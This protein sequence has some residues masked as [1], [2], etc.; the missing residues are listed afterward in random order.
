MDFQV[1]ITYQFGIS[2]SA[3]YGIGELTFKDDGLKSC[4]LAEPFSRLTDKRG[5][6][7]DLKPVV[8][9]DWPGLCVS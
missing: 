2:A 3:V 9:A 7:Q 6:R 1:Y 4:R 5:K 8:G